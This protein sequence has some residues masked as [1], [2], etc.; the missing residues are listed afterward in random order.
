[1]R[2]DIQLK[3]KNNK[4]YLRYLRA[5]SYWYKFLNRDPSRFNEFVEN[6]KSEYRLRPTDRISDAL[7][8]LEMLSKVVSTLK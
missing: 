5:N 7:S 1:M 2:T 4:Y 6:V 8:T 3:I